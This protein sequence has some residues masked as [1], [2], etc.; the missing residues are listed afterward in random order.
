MDKQ[1]FIK[2]ILTNCKYLS[3]KDRERLMKLCA[4]EMNR[5]I[6]KKQDIEQ[7][8]KEIYQTTT[9]ITNED[10]SAIQ[11]NLNTNVSKNT[12]RDMI[13]LQHNP[14]ETCAFLSEFSRSDE[15]KWF[16][17]RADCDISL[18]S[19]AE[20]AKTFLWKYKDKVSYETWLNVRNFIS[21]NDKYINVPWENYAG[22]KVRYHWN[23]V[24]KWMQEYPDKDPFDYPVNG[25]NKFSYYI[26]QFKHTIQFRTDNR[27]MLFYRRIK[28]WLKI[29]LGNNDIKVTYS[30][31][32]RSLGS[33]VYTFIDVRI[34]FQMLK[35]VCA[36][37]YDHKKESNYVDIDLLAPENKDYYEFIILHRGSYLNIPE[38]KM[39]GLSGDLNKLR[40]LAF[41]NLDL[42]ID[43]D[44]GSSLDKREGK[45]LICMNE[46]VKGIRIKD[47]PY[48]KIEQ[49]IVPLECEKV[50]GVKYIF[51]FYKLR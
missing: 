39:K 38:V 34:F 26:Q 25:E 14:K 43:A 22:E 20:A 32:F 4:Q 12:P 27:E 29:K 40:V 35:E 6:V 1:E 51:R 19:Y 31:N 7:I 13:Y 2:D 33:S 11:D 10:S 9:A 3:L 49:G 5:D 36:W 24:K 46:N 18:E 37:I 21:L 41:N 8:V 28:Q 44:C 47:K 30:E 15:C 17:H 42:E 45:K 23:S 16:T 48:Y 50:G